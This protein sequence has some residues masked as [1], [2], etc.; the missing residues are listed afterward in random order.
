LMRAAAFA[1]RSRDFSRVIGDV[2]DI[3][4]SE[5]VLTGHTAHICLRRLN[6]A[7]GIHDPAAL[8]CVI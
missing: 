5:Y 7:M 3:A 4:V 2:S 6:N 8:P 1:F